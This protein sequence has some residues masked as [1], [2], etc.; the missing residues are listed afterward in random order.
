MGVGCHLRNIFLS[1]LLYADDMA[2]LTP[3]LNGLQKLLSA[4]EHYCKT[5]DIML[6]AKKTKNLYFGKRHNPVNLRLGGKD[7]E[8]VTTWPYLGVHIK[9]HTS[10]NCC[11]DNKVKYFYRCANGILRIEGRSSETVML[12]LLE[13]HCLPIL[14]YTIE[15]IHVADRDVRRKMRVAY[16]SLFRKVFNYRQWE[17]VTELQHSLQH[18]LQRP[19]WEELVDIRTNKFLNRV[20]QS[21][22]LG[23]IS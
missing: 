18:S 17:S 3:S 12:Q 9:S 23:S 4:T 7:I 8:W 6:N 1:I 11:I 5:W 13:T 19:T 16:N 2:L 10:F 21:D 15:V 14:T 22:F 20:K